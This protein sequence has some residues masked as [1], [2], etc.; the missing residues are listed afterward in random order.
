MRVCS[1]YKRPNA[2]KCTEH[3]LEKSLKQIYSRKVQN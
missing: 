2:D 1:R 3:L